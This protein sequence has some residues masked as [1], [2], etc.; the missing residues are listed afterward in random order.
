MH[1]V[2]V[3]LIALQAG[4]IHELFSKELDLFAVAI[5]SVADVPCSYPAI[6]MVW[7]F[8][9]GLDL[10]LL[11]FVRIL[12]LLARGLLLQIMEWLRVLLYVLCIHACIA[13]RLFLLFH[14][15]VQTF[16]LW[17]RPSI[18]EPPPMTSAEASLLT[19]S[20]A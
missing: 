12:L 19:T 1:S 4:S 8:A 20:Y 16:A 2:L 14:L 10:L 5:A 7:L 3:L 18:D 13:C 6:G 15:W 17:G 11:S 9:S